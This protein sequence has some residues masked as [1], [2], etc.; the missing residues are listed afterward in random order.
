MSIDVS[1][2]AVSLTGIAGL[3]F[4]DDVI[5]RIFDIEYWIQSDLSIPQAVFSSRQQFG[6]INRET[7]GMAGAGK[8]STV[9]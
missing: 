2:K 5:F 6:D 8:V 1:F 7:P 9:R 3:R 4:A